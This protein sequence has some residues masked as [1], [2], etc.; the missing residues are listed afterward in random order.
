MAAFGLLAGLGHALEG[1]GERGVVHNHDKLAYPARLREVKRRLEVR[2]CKGDDLGF[3][4]K[5]AEVF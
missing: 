5:G 4:G 1:D 3:L 2:R